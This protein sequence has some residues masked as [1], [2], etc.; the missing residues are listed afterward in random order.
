MAR[1]DFSHQFQPCK[2]YSQ[3]AC[4]CWA[5]TGRRYVRKLGTEKGGAQK[6]NNTEQPSCCRVNTGTFLAPLKGRSEW[7]QIYRV[8]S[9]NRPSGKITT[10]QSCK[11]QCVLY[12]AFVSTKIY[13][14]PTQCICV[15]FMVTPCI[16]DINPFLVQLMHLYSLLKQD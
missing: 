14:L 1:S 6:F 12:L 8:L 3:C 11:E 15:I 9:T 4:T 5:G 7:V 10:A 16:N 2:D 13:T